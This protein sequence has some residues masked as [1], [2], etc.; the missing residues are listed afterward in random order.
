MGSSGQLNI[1]SMKKILLL[2]AVLFCYKLGYAQG[3]FTSS[4]SGDAGDW[5]A[6]GTWTLASGADTDGVPDADDTVTISSGDVVTVTATAAAT[7]LTVTGTLVTEAA[8]TI[9]GNVTASGSTTLNGGNVVVSGDFTNS[10]TL[11]L[12]AGSYLQ[13]DDDSKTLTNTGAIEALG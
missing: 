2:I 8:L 5:N 10:G 1:T 7:T 11:K 12:F 4:P 6:S 3:T 13:L 9:S